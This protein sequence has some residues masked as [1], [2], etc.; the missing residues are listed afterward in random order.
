ML[1]VHI[2]NLPNL[3]NILVMIKL[4]AAPGYKNPGIDNLSLIGYLR[5]LYPPGPPTY[6]TPFKAEL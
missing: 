1:K 4:M 5:D 6:Q 2:L 3:S